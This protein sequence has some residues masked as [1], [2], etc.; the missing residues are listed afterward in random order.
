M[1][2]N[3]LA[4]ISLMLLTVLFF[5]GCQKEPTE[6]KLSALTANRSNTNACRMLA[7]DWQTVAKWE[8]HYNDKGLA[9]Q[10]TIDY[11]FGLPLHTNEM[12]YDENNRLIRSDE[13]YFGSGYVYHFYYTGKRLT[14]L[15]RENIDVPE[16][17]S[18]F[19]FTYNSK[20]QVIRQDD[21]ALDAHVLL[22]YDKEGNNTRT[23]LYFGTDLVFSD[24]YT[25]DVP[26]NNPRSAVPGV[27]IG[28]PFYGTAGMSDKS[29]FTSNRTEAYENGELILFNDYDP[30]QTVLVNGNHNY[31]SSAT[32][33]DRVTEE[34]ITITFGYENCNGTTGMRNAGN[35]KSY[36]GEGNAKRFAKPML[37]T[38]SKKSVME[39]TENMKRLLRK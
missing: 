36:A 5:F 14:R 19:I 37:V 33:Y 22:A 4:P 10:W 39:Q 17:A 9:D 6:N 32:Y 29:W 26:S 15:T 13:L 7:N 8:F 2:K 18:D 12:T 20:E 23:D 1:K 30:A 25:F 16:D 38:G 31:P 21:E 24:I 34:H 35:S 28:F 3:S 27:T 11:G